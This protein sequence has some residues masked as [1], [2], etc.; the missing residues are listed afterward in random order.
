MLRLGGAGRGD[1]DDPGARQCD[2]QSDPGEALFGPLGRAKLGLRAGGVAERM[3]F[4]EQN[5]AV[6]IR[7][8]PVEQLLQAR[9]EVMALGAMRRIGE[10]DDRSEERR[11]RQGR[12]TNGRFWWFPCC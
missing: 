7:P 6:E 3:R 4:V 1:V 12:V 11:V 8:R 9:C 10:E 2:L 5:D